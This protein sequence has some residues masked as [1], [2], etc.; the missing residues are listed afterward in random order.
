MR[1]RLGSAT[2]LN[3]FEVDGPSLLQK[4]KA[5]QR[6]A[7]VGDAPNDLDAA[8]ECW[9]L[10]ESNSKP[11]AWL[12]LVLPTDALRRA[13]APSVPTCAGANHQ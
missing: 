3:N 5:S 13:D 10:G 6:L 1:P 2:P 4:E 7:R 9:H 8:A 11:P 12:R